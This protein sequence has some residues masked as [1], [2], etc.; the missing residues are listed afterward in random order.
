MKN[1]IETS[2][3]TA[4]INLFE[5]EK[6]LLAVTCFEA[7]NS[8][9]NK[10]SD[11]K[12]FPISTPSFWTPKRTEETINKLDE[13]LELRPQSDIELHVKEVKKEALE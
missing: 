11:N 2:S 8:V 5:E 12:N 4:P 9:C 1:Q 13:V 3:S 6:W 10:T 7:T